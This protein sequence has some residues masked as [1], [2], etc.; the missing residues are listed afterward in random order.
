MVEVKDEEEDEEALQAETLTTRNFGEPH[1]SVSAL[2]RITTFKTMRVTGSYKKKNIAYT[3]NVLD[4]HVAKKLS[5]KM[6]A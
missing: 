6:E 2:T 1:I 4:I 5:C 3:H